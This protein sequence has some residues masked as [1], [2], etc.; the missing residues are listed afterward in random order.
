MNDREIDAI[1]EE[2]TA[3]LDGE[4]TS[5]ESAALERRLVQDEYLRTRLADLRKAYDLLDELPETPHSNH[6]TQTTIE[7]VVADVKRSGIRPATVL[8]DSIKKPPRRDWKRRWFSMPYA[9]VPL[10]LAI[11]LGSGLGISASMMRQRRELAVLDLASNLPGLHDTGELRVVEEVAKNKEII[12]YL[13]EHYRDSLIP[14]VPKSF[15][16]RQTWVRGLN[17]IQLAKLDSAREL[18]GKYPHEVSQR[19]DAVQEQINSQP[20]AE[21]LNLTARMIGAVFDTIPTSK[22][23]VLED[24]NI[25]SKISF[26]LKQIAFRAATF[27]AADLQGSDAEALDEWSKSMLMPS[28]MTSMPF[29]R[30][31]T[32]VKSALM[33]LNSARPVEEGFRLDNQDALISDLA[34]RLTPF[35]KSLLESID[36]SDQL[37]VISTWMIPEG[38]NST[39]RLLES[40]ERL[41]R[42]SRDE[43]D[44]ADPKDIRRLLRERSRRPGN[45]NRPPR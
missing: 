32:D 39:S 43:I 25:S 36:E 20:N 1:D 10:L 16:E 31:E 17:S 5:S 18:L 9:V 45:T 28:I 41:R 24:L 15:S 29:L 21:E 7:M 19:L 12:E 4:L 14:Q 44:L 33:A 30:R 26:I 13:Q 11:L 2:L 37:L 23:Q 3:Y 38:M 42:E 22:R 8:E 40:Y 34:S 35:P 27:Y 6:F